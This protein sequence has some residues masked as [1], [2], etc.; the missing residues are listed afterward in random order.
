MFYEAK[1]ENDHLYVF[2]Y[3]KEKNN[4]WYSEYLFRGS[5]YEEKEKIKSNEKKKS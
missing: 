4:K 5:Y 1:K 3:D 2:K